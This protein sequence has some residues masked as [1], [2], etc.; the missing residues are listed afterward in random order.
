M[1]APVP[2][3]LAESFQPVVGTAVTLRPLRPDDVD[4]ESAF[5]R[6]LSPDTRHNR[7]LGGAIAITREYLERLTRIEYSRDMALAA[8]VMLEREILIGVA[9]YVRD[10]SGNAAEFAIVVADTWHGRGIGKRLLERLATIA[11]KRGLR[12]LYGDVLA[13]NRPML[14]LVKK[15]GFSLSRNPDDPALTRATLTL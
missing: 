10:A 13:V 5:V 4:I 1:P 12:Q 3:D 14:G 15:L 8:T 6:G 7:L 9:R 2:D 11:R